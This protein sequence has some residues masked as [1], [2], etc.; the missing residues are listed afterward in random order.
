[1]S[2]GKNSSGGTDRRAFIDSAAKAALAAG[3]FASVGMRQA[4]AQAKLAG[5]PLLTAQ[6]V[7]ALLPPPGPQLQQHIAEMKVNLVAYLQKY[8]YLTDAQARKGQA[9]QVQL[10]EALDK[11]AQQNLAIQV[12]PMALKGFQYAVVG[13]T[14][15]IKIGP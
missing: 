9:V 12:E 5:K 15:V 2:K 7:T 6:T 4:L 10:N 8:F 11:A 14:L 13:Q 1:M 3:C